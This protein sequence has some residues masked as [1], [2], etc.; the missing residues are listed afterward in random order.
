MKEQNMQMQQMAQQAQ[1]NPQMA[2]QLQQAQQEFMRVK[3]SRISE[4]E[5]EMIKEMAKQEQEKAGNM[6]QDPLVR[7]KQQEIDLRAVELA[8]KQEQE[9]N[10]IMANIGIEAEKLDLARD[11]MKA[12]GEEVVFKEGL[13][14]V[15]ESDKQTIEDI[16]ENMETLREDR[17]LQ[18]AEKLATLNKGNNGRQTDDN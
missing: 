11:Q 3:E 12:K 16:K 5:A 6:T 10:K 17:R 1:Q 13:K 8:A 15:A 4:L 7:L 9:D 14:A 18:S 2:Q